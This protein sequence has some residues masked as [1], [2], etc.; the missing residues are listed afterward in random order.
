M[1]FSNLSDN[2]WIFLA[3]Q[4][5]AFVTI[6]FEMY[7]GFKRLKEDMKEVKETQKIHTKDLSGFGKLLNTARWQAECAQREKEE[8]EKKMEVESRKARLRGEN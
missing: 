7:F 3:G 1:D 2:V 4:F 8:Y 5:V 6:Q